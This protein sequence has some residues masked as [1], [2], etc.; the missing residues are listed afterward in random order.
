M[1][2]IARVRTAFGRRCNKQPRGAR[3]CV[4]TRR[5]DH[6]SAPRSQAHRRASSSG[7]AAC[8]A[9]PVVDIGAW[10]DPQGRQECRH[11]VAAEWDAAMTRCGFAVITGHG[12]E[13]R[14]TDALD[15]SARKF[16][17]LPLAG[18]AVHG[19]PNVYGPEGYTCEGVEA[20][21]RSAAVSNR[22]RGDG[23]HSRPPAA[24]VPPDPV[25]SFVFQQPPPS[26]ADAQHGRP[27]PSH[28]RDLVS[29]AREYW[30]AMDS[31]LESLHRLSAHALG[32]E[33]DFFQRPFAYPNR[34]SLR[35]AYYPSR[36]HN[37]VSRVAS[38]T[39]LHWSLLITFVWSCHLQHRAR[40]HGTVPT[41]ITR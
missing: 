39:L 16:F 9:I 31:V 12:V 32:Q 6:A 26:A 30:S 24:D 20:V 29:A 23:D 7:T 1:Q 36:A 33:P 21:E 2:R 19:D 18:K 5:L 4:L 22:R 10:V 25:E 41:R 37:G 38:G 27:M 28:P 13:S 34:N 3:V 15:A 17:E 35:L 14:V 40:S 8:D 11:R